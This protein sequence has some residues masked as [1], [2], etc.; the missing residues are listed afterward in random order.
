M[1]LLQ[2]VDKVFRRRITVEQLKVKLHAP[3]DRRPGEGGQR[4]AV[5]VAIPVY[6]LALIKSCT[7]LRM[8]SHLFVHGTGG[9][10][11]GFARGWRVEMLRELKNGSCGD[12][13]LGGK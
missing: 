3:I 13:T 5:I 11:V 1:K 4:R 10:I 12:A 8:F 7:F 2:G 9:W 6:L